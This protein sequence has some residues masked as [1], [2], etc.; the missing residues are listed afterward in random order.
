VLCLSCSLYGGNKE[1]R[2]TQKCAG[3]RLE[4][5]AMQCVTLPVD[6]DTARCHWAL[7]DDL[8]IYESERTDNF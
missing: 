5:S 4:D 8:P 1:I 3:A 6:G 7:E 2:V